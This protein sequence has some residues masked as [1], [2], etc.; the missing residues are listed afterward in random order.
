MQMRILGDLLTSA[1]MIGSMPKISWVAARDLHGFV[2]P[3]VD[4]QTL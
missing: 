2:K 1:S 3:I 4:C